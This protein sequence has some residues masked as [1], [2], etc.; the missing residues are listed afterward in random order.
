[1]MMGTK[2]GVPRNL[3]AIKFENF[4]TDNQMNDRTVKLDWD[5][6]IANHSL[7]FGGAFNHL[8]FDY[9]W[10]QLFNRIDQEGLVIFFDQAPDAFSYNRTLK[11]YS[12]YLED[13]WRI[14]D[15]LTVRPG[16]PS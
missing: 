3:A 10:Q 15:R 2:T 1:M 13:L 7:S 4:E 16:V 8:K 6:E 11:Q 12:F 5:L 14:G 9:K